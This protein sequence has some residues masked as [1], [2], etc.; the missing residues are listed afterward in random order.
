MIIVIA[1]LSILLFVACVALFVQRRGLVIL[2]EKYWDENRLHLETKTKLESKYHGALDEISELEAKRFE[3]WERAEVLEQKNIE[4]K[5]ELS[6]RQ[7]P[8][9]DVD[10][11]KEQ[12]NFVRT[13]R[14]KRATPG[15]YRNVFDLDINGQ[16]VLE[17][18][19]TVFC[20]DAFVSN[21]K[22]GERETCRRLGEQGVIN[23]IVNNINQANDPNYKEQDND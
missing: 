14:L 4:L 1:I 6:E 9:Q 8:V 12:G 19:T 3:Q 20:K 5:H 2:E 15:T 18:L 22:G 7:L 23:F 10:E 17:H 16:R 11:S 21:D 13:K